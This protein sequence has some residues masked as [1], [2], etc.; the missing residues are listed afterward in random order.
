MRRVVLILLL[1]FPKLINAQDLE[2]SWPI[3]ETEP[4]FEKNKIN[5]IIDT[6]VEDFFLKET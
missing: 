6:V 1:L 2:S 3:K 5:Q 4:V